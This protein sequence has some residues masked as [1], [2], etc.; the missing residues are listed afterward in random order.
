MPETAA[1]EASTP[2]VHRTTTTTKMHSAASAT[3]VGASCGATKM[4]SATASGEARASAAEMR[5][6]SG[7]G[8]ERG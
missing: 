5:A 2:G 6:A 1:A 8:M 7:H 3:E 4:H